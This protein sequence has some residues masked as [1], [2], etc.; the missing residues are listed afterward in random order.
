MS[1]DV[2]RGHQILLEHD[3]SSCETQCGYRDPKPGSLQK[4]KCSLLRHLSSNKS[5]NFKSHV[6]D[7]NTLVS[8]PFKI[9]YCWAVVAHAFNPSTWEAEAGVSL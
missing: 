8:K 2:C 4:N 9:I 6:L 3:Y 5:C 1:I 7:R